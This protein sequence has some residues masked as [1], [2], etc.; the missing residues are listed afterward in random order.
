MGGQVVNPKSCAIS[1]KNRISGLHLI[2]LKFSKVPYAVLYKLKETDDQE[3]LNVFG[4][5][6]GIKNMRAK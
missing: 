3:T 6:E 1:Y 2:E 4:L 5:S